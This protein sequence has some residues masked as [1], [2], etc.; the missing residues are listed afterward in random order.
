MVTQGGR[1]LSYTHPVAH[2]PTFLLV[3]SPAVGKSTTAKALAQR[4]AKGVHIPVDT[5]RDMVVSGLEMPALQ[6]SDSLA[7]QVRLA[8]ETALFM[9]KQYSQAGFAVVLDDFYDPHGL[10][11]YQPLI[12]RGEVRGVILFPTI[13][14][15]LRR[16]F[17][18]FGDQPVRQYLDEGI[19]N[20][21]GMLEPN[22]AKLKE[23]GW[24]VVDTT[25]MSLE[26]AVEELSR[27]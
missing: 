18:R 25:E 3:G 16:N 9:A 17:G 12:E 10:L 24:K 14:E 15:A 6:W 22:L 21:Y 2:N 8:R 5:L 11:E 13:K 23:Q 4:F 20:V 7:Q 26:Q 27:L 19:R 1:H